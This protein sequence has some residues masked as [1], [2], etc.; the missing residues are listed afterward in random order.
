MILRR[1]IP[2]EAG[3]ISD[4]MDY[5]RQKVTEWVGQDIS[6]AFIASVARRGVVFFEEAFGKQFAP[7]QDEA[8]TTET[9]FPLY[10]VSKAVVSVLAMSMMEDGLI[11]INRN[12]DSYLPELEG[13]GKSEIYVHQLFTH[14]TGMV[15]EDMWAYVTEQM[16]EY[17][18][19]PSAY[20]I[21]N[22]MD[23]WIFFSCKAPLAMRPGECMSYNSL[24]FKLL[25]IILSRLG[26]KPLDTLLRERLFE[27]LGMKSTFLVVP[28]ERRRDVYAFPEDCEV[29]THPNS[30]RQLNSQNP[31]GGMYSHGGRHAPFRPDAAQRREL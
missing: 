23:P 16:K 8:V 22:D 21:P 29:G 26:G 1:G 20:E 14:T 6:P 13:E 2:S 3:M 24:G 30:V 9:I 25:G 19:N 10:S 31:A 7:R 15:E 5:A 18:R 12:L 17:R 27:P 28:Q 11:S 4:R